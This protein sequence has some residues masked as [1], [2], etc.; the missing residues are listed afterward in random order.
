MN[1]SLRPY[2]R[3]TPD[4]LQELLATLRGRTVAVVGLGK[5]GTTAAELLVRLGAAGVDVLD[6]KRPEELRETAAA[7]AAVGNIRVLGGG[8]SVERAAGAELV[9]MSPGVPRRGA[10]WD[11]MVA[12]GTPWMGEAELAWRATRAP[13]LCITGTNGK[14]T[15]TVMLGT[16]VKAAGG[17]TFV[18]GNL[19]DPV[20]RAAYADEE[21]NHLVVEM[22]SYQCEGIS[23]LDATS[24]ILTNL[25]PD[26]LAR[27]K[28]ASRY[29]EAKLRLLELQDPRHIA[30]T[31]AGDPECAA[32]A[33]R[34]RGTRLDFNVATG[35]EG[36]HIDG[37]RLLLRR[38]DVTE[39]YTAGN[40]RIRGAHNLE[41]AAAAVAAARAA[42][43]PQ[44]AVQAGLDAFV[45]VPHRL[46]EIA[47]LDGV[48]YVNDSK[49]TNVDATVKAISSFTE[50]IHLIAGGED[51]GTS[52]EPMAHAARGRVKA[53]YTI[54]QA[55]PLISAAMEHTCVVLD[56]GTMDRALERARSVA[57]PG[58][59]VLLSPACA[60]FDQ[61][62]NYEHR[63]EAF[64]AW[65]RARAGGAA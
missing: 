4:R 20:C 36:V 40:P 65:V 53:V 1:L 41:N 2:T 35:H 62:K 55:A 19:G 64:A 44:A 31:N 17:R 45:P 11:A 10:W 38:G 46:E 23:T 29:Y 54:G 12:A 24:A 27:Y 51:K 21:W 33:P 3:G 32:W 15:T 48:L 47:T 43:I 18:G 28:V 22:S 5:S 56:C 61:F 37:R 42:D 13:W 39:V 34:A 8:I 49:G 30:V 7:L 14:S 25:T 26:H 6:D 58:E 59:V 52:Y 16:L 57:K 63:G 50:P 9:V 60:S